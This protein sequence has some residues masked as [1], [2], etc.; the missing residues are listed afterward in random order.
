MTLTKNVNDLYKEN[1]KPL[2]KETEE[3]N[4]NWEDPP[5]S[6]TGRIKKLKMATLPKAIYML[7]TIPTKSQ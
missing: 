4:R 5:R 7:N 2:K 1:C 6:W 3:G